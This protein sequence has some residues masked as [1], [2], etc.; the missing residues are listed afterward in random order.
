MQTTDSLLLAVAIEFMFS[1]LCSTAILVWTCKGFRNYPEIFSQYRISIPVLASMSCSCLSSVIGLLGMTDVYVPI[2]LWS[3]RF[4]YPTSMLFFYL[5]KLFMYWS[6]IGRLEF[7]FEETAYRVRGL[8]TNIC[9][10][11]T[12]ICTLSLYS[13]WIYEVSVDLRPHVATHDYQSCWPLFGR[14]RD[15]VFHVL[16]MTAYND[17]IWGS[18]L[19]FLYSYQLYQITVSAEKVMDA[20]QYTLMAE[21]ANGRS[22]SA[23]QSISRQTISTW[24][25]RILHPVDQNT[26]LV[27]A[28]RKTL[29]LSFLGM[30]K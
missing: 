24:K 25:R 9:R 23:H 22:K 6:L 10:V 27:F 20:Y 15:F 21:A 11:S 2:T 1:L 18:I 16:E 14:D 19:S 3:C 8:V 13:L 12:L 5:G 28:I 17:I 26:Q 30:Y 4:V 7:I 29:I